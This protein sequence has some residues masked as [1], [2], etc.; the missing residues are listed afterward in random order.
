[1]LNLIQLKYTWA[2]MAADVQEFSKGCSLCSIYK[3]ANWGAQEIGTPR[4]VLEPAKFWQIDVC[5]GLNAVNG[6]KSFLTMVDMYTGFVIAVPLKS[7]TTPEIAKVVENYLIK[8]FG[9]PSE[10]SSDNAANLTGPAMKKLCAFYNIKY[11]NTVPY[12]PTSHALVEIANRYIV[13]LMRIFSDQFQTHWPNVICLATLIYNSVP[14]SQLMG[15]SPFYML[16]Q[17]E[18]F[19]ANEFSYNNVNNLD[20]A[21]YVQRSINDRVFTKILRERLLKIREKRNRARELP[22]RSYPK[23]SL[24]LVRDL[25]PKVNKKMK[26]IYFKLPQKVVSEYRCTVYASDLFGR[27]RKHSK[28]NIRLLSPRGVE[29]FSKLPEDMKIIL[30]DAFNEEKW[31]EIKDSGIIPAYLA[32][33]EIEG[34]LGRQTR[35]NISQESHLIETTPPP[36]VENN[37]ENLADEGEGDEIE[38]LLSDDLLSKLNVLHEREELMEPSLT[39]KDI[40]K[41]Y[42]EVT[43]KD[44]DPAVRRGIQDNQVLEQL[45]EG[46]DLV[47]DEEAEDEV[48]PDPAG[49]NVENI[50]PYRTRR[51]VRFALPQLN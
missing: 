24:I 5:S 17:K 10:I 28:N 13:Q 19:A 45:D 2:N 30:G 38:E 12:S 18:P 33:I 35:G 39:L 21:D 49:I 8:I 23:G 32:D 1:M 40:P 41:L 11:R 37:T 20:M 7:E 46:G 27:I 47:D 25:R 16:F 51:R 6:Q 14:R 34:E 26:Q 29:L 3:S 22:Y 15:H 31:D 42:D 9:P 4:I 43:S 44:P 50:L 36:N 48:Q